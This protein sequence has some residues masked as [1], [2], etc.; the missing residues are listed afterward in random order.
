MKP[1]RSFVLVDDNAGA[2]VTPEVL[3]KI[4][5]AI[6]LQ[7]YEDFAP[8]WG[9]PGVTVITGPAPTSK[10]DTSIPVY[11]RS[12]SDVPGA[13]GYH[14]D[15][16]VY[17]FR[18]G[19]PELTSG[20][21]SLSVVVSHEILETLGDPG[22]NRWAD[23]GDGTEV[24]LELC[25]AVEANCYDKGGVSVSDFVLPS[26][27]DGGGVA[28]YS[29]MG[30]PSKPFTTASAGGADY[31]IERTGGSDEKQVTADLAG[32]PRAKVKLMSS[33]RTF[34]RGVVI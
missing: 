6:Q 16:G 7:I 9:N 18:D 34:R 27:F 11:V 1:I 21:F 19:L 20:A 33:S 10:A 23:T 28:P 12:S 3:A 15:E 5:T 29:H 30:K 31:Q 22:A 24:A 8:Y 4:A 13:A 32:H 2:D 25:D 26:F 17:V 14:D